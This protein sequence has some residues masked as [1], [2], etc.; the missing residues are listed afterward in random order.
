MLVAKMANFLGGDEATPLSYPLVELLF[1][2]RN[3]FNHSKF[4]R[5]GDFHAS[6]YRRRALK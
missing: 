1:L 6:F 3:D 5:R 2:R 4:K